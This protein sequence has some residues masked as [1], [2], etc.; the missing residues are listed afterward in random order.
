MNANVLSSERGA[1]FIPANKT[2]VTD[3]N[4][5]LHI[6]VV[7]D[8]INVRKTL[9][10]SLETDGHQVVGVSNGEDALA[11]AAHNHFDVAFVDL[12]LKNKSGADLIPELIAKSPWMR[13]VVITA[14]A[15]VDS[16]V[17]TMKRGAVDYITKPFTPKQIKKITDALASRNGKAHSADDTDGK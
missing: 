15:S 9:A 6:L 13:I 12:R 3:A 2:M 11:E 4:S 5:R 8:E 16:A 10:I 17:E 14:F 1:E 7:D